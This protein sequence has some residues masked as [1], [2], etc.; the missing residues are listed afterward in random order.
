MMTAATIAL[1]ALL[2]T[3]SAQDNTTTTV[4]TS[5]VAPEVQLPPD[6]IPVATQQ[7]SGLP[8]RAPDPRTLRELWPV[9]AGFTVA[10]L[11]ILAYVLSVGG[12]FSRLSREVAEIDQRSGSGTIR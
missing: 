5:E 3:S 6:I 4:P 7:P 1:L 11:G 10:W 2:A 8:Q 9:F 12:R